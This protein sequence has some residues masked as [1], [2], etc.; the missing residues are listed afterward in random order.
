MQEIISFIIATSSPVLK[1]NKQLHKSHSKVSGHAALLVLCNQRW[2]VIDF[3]YLFFKITQLRINYEDK[4]TQRCFY[5]NKNL[6]P[7]R[8]HITQQ[9][10]V[11]AK[12]LSSKDN[13]IGEKRNKIWG[14]NVTTKTKQLWQLQAPMFHNCLYLFMP[15]HIHGPCWAQ[16]F[17]AWDENE[18]RAHVPV[19]MP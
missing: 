8:D 18:Q 4:I 9:Q 11:Y 17:L 1:I 13:R 10:P 6:W 2:K 16:R 7:T 3:L 5:R 19:P 14:L 15:S 12:Q